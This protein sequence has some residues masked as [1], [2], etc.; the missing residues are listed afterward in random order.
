MP[1]ERPDMNSRFLAALL[2]GL[3]VHAGDYPARGLLCES[4]LLTA[5]VIRPCIC[6]RLCS[7]MNLF[8]TCLHKTQVEVIALR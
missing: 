4:K 3:H 5:D 8:Q 6:S 7:Q 1:A 2:C